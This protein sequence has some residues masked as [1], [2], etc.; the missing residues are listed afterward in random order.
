MRILIS[1]ASGMVGRALVASLSR[2]SATTRFSPEIYTLVRRAPTSSHEIFFD[3]SS[4]I[5]AKGCEGF[6]A[7]IHL[8]GENVG[9]GSGPLA[10]LGRWDENK[11]HDILH[12]RRA[13]TALLSKALAACRKKPRVLV[14]A[15][16][17]GFYGTDGGD[18]ELDEIAPM[19]K[20]FLAQVA[21][22]W[23]ENTAP[24]R[25]AGIR[26]V[27]LRFGVVLSKTGG[28]IGENERKRGGVFKKQLFL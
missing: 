16:G 1:G 18:K 24:A 6:D 15:S 10:F 5:D 7:V 4:R 17:V 13:G 2:P 9:S 21:R 28:V 22:V 27:N 8:A 20:G 25:D 26:V 3:S 12:S 14:S 19:G 23:E 11:K